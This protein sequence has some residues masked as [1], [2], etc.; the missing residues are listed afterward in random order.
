MHATTEKLIRYI[1]ALALTLSAGGANAATQSTNSFNTTEMNYGFFFSDDVTELQLTDLSFGARMNAWTNDVLTPA[2]IVFTGPTVQPLRGLMRLTFDYQAPQVGY[3][4]A[5]VLFDGVNHAIQDSGTVAFDSTLRGP[6]AWSS[7][8]AFSAL[9]TQHID[10][11]FNRPGAAAVPL[12]KS[13]ALMLSAMA[14][15]GFNRRSD[16]TGRETNQA[17]RGQRN[18]T[19]YQA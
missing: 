5:M 17:E 9:N 6:S 1:W 13:A 19:R 12:P 16:A 8:S 15:V 18:V 10:N 7:S 14:I 4:W 3:Q 11:Y 2:E